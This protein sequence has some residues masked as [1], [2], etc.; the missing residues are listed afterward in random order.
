MT[1]FAEIL[2]VLRPGGRLHLLDFTHGRSSFGG[3]LAR[4]LHPEHQLTDNTRD[5]VLALMTESG[6]GSPRIVSRAS[7][8][9]MPTAC[10]EA[11]V[12]GE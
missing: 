5:R 11:V 12:P 2:R 8:L 9:T 10:Y 3:A 4:W 1:G 6:L 7:L